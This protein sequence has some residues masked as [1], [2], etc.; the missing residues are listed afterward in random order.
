MDS[1][2][3][4]DAPDLQE[5]VERFEARLEKLRTITEGWRDQKSVMQDARRLLASHRLNYTSQGAERLEI[6]WWEW[7]PE[8]WESLR[9]GG[10]MNFM[11][12]PALI[13]EENGKMTESQ[14]AISIAF[15]T[16]LISMGV[17]ALVPHGVLLV[18]V[19]P[20]FLVAKPGQPDQWICIADMKKGH[21]NKSCAADPV[22]MTCPEDILPRMYPGGFYSAID[23]SKFFH[24]F[25]TVEE[26]RQFMG[27]IHPCTGDLYWYT[28]LPMGSSK[29]PAVSGRF[30]AAF[31]RLIF[32]EVE[33]MQG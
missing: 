12:T 33:E 6:L 10:S 21:Q 13:L 2:F 23:A 5:G 24:V 27:L 29:S 9:F 19:C 25:L 14:L 32:Q 11:E 7:P 8:H 15:V 28:R 3:E 20:L 17:M 18:N 31:L 26:E 16:E 30:G 4:W 1:P 22:H